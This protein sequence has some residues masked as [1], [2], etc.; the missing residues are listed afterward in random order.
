MI[1][2]LTTNLLDWMYKSN[3]EWRNEQGDMFTKFN[4]LANIV[5]GLCTYDEEIEDKWG[6][7]IFEVLITILNNETFK[8]IMNEKQYEQFLLVCQL[9]KQRNWIE[10]GTSV[11]SCWFDD[12]E[13]SEPVMI[14]MLGV[15]ANDKRYDGEGV[16]WSIDNLTI[17]LKWLEK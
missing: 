12:N 5:F 17:L 2:N 14:E 3:K 15:P 4:F 7:E 16:A 6:K 11:R 10:W 9:L 8:F 1:K 13:W